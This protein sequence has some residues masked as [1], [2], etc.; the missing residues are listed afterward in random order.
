MHA[1]ISGNVNSSGG[2]IKNEI[3]WNQQYQKNYKNKFLENLENVHYSLP[4]F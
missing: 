3:T 2:A 1:N 4:F